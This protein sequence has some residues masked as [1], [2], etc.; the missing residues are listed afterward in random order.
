[1]ISMHLG[2]SFPLGKI[3]IT[4]NA[5]YQVPLKGLVRALKRQA[6]GGSA[7]RADAEAERRSAESSGAAGASKTWTRK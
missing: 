7:P 2:P 6:T 4:T 3:I 5:I 1:M